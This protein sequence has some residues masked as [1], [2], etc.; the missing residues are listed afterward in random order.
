MGNPATSHRNRLPNTVP[1]YHTKGCSPVCAT[2]APLLFVVLQL[3][4]AHYVVL[5]LYVVFVGIIVCK[6][7]Q[8]NLEGSSILICEVLKWL[9]SDGQSR[10]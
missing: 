8:Y 4:Y 9:A 7:A 1:Y 2:Y 6:K 10:H 3:S 5:Q